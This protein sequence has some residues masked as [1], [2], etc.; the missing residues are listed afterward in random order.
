[1]PVPMF[2]VITK[3]GGRVTTIAED[4]MDPTSNR[5]DGAERA[6]VNGVMMDGLTHSAIF[7]I[8]DFEGAFVCLE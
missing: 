5:L 3:E 2:V 8:A 1:M 6:G 7:L 4:V